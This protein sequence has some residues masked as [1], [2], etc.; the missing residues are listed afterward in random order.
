M[1]VT[2]EQVLKA[3]KT[4]LPSFLLSQGIKLKRDGSKSYKHPDHDSLVFTA[5]MYYWNSRNESGNAI[6]YLTR[7]LDYSFQDAVMAL[8]K[9]EGAKTDISQDQADSFK[10]NYECAKFLQ[11]NVNH[12][13]KPEEVKHLTKFLYN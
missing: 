1:Q 11:S 4:D 3:R 2:R 13:K 9:H 10:L 12:N 6:D 7:N 8:V 5:N